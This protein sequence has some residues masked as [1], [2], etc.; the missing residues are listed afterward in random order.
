MRAYVLQLKWYPSYRTV[1]LFLKMFRLFIV[2]LFSFVDLF[3]CVFC[4]KEN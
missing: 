4:F 3:V 1:F 2:Y